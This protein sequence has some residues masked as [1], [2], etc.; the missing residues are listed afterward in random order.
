MRV[1]TSPDVIEAQIEARN[2]LSAETK[3]HGENLDRAAELEGLLELLRERVTDDESIPNGVITVI[4]LAERLARK[5]A[6]RLN[7]GPDLS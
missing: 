7:C 4:Q 6:E 3:W 2:R 5:L 1:A